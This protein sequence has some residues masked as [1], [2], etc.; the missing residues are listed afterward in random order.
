MGTVSDASAPVGAQSAPGRSR[1]VLR[2]ASVSALL[3]TPLASPEGAAQTPIVVQPAG[4]NL[5]NAPSGAVIGFVTGSTRLTGESAV[6]DWRPVVLEG[7]IWALSVGPTGAGSLQVDPADGENLRDSPNGRI[8]ARLES[9]AVLE[10]LRRD[11]RWVRVRRRAWMWSASVRDVSPNRSPASSAEPAG[12]R[13]GGD[14]DAGAGARRASDEAG[15]TDAN[16]ADGSRA[17]SGSVEAESGAPARVLTVGPEGATLRGAPGDSAIGSVRA[18]TEVS[19]VERRGQWARVRVEGWLRAPEVA[20]DTAAPRTGVTVRDLADHPERYQGTR[21]RWTVQF[22][23]LERAERIRTEFYAGEPYLLARGP[24]EDR[25]I[26]YLAVPSALMDRVERLEPLDRIEVVGRVRTP[27]S[28][29]TGA[30]VLDLQE[31]R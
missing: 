17:G 3:A 15:A 6:G 4:E 31:I 5:R 14:G 12:A 29:L 20:Q 18:G 1:V 23:S 9:G 7:W 26:V 28:P 25:P 10:E 8:L 19:V 22:I 21:V 24:G 13:S 30:P 11:G 16:G 2:I 27:R